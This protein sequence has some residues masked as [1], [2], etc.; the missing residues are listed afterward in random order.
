[1]SDDVDEESLDDLVAVVVEHSVV[2]EIDRTRGT[3][4]ASRDGDDTKDLS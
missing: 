1:L 2:S 4:P 3:A